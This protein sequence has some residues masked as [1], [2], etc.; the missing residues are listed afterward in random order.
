MGALCKATTAVRRGQQEVK[1][2]QPSSALRG[3]N[4]AVTVAVPDWGA[5]TNS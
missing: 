4:G 3:A 1:R 5:R 2:T